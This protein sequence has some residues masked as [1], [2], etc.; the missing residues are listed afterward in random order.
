MSKLPGILLDPKT[1]NF[2]VDPSLPQNERWK[3]FRLSMRPRLEQKQQFI[4]L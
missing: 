1:N 3:K 2:P 4:D